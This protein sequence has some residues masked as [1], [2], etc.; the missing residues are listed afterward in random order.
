MF[1]LHLP[2][3]KSKILYHVRRKVAMQSAKSGRA[4]AGAGDEKKEEHRKRCTEKR[5]VMC[6][7][8]R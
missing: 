2:H 6:F 8:G 1:C 7:T 3:R 4:R 5:P